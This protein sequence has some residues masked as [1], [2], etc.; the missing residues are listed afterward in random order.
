MSTAIRHHLIVGTL[1][2]LCLGA[3]VA[4]EM[5]SVVHAAEGDEVEY[6]F[7][8]PITE[9]EHTY[10]WYR[11]THADEA[12]KRYGVD[13]D[14]VGDGM[15]TWH[16]WVGVDNPEFPGGSWP[17]SVAGRTIARSMRAWTSSA[18]CSRRRARIVGPTWVSSTIRTPSPQTSPTSM[19]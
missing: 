12:A 19:A 16:W 7:G 4:G 1:A 8:R 11:K 10:D 3:L 18:C 6:T 9:G 15:D 2:A 14:A 5:R 17:F 13:P